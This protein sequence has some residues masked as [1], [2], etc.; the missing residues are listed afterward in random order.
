[1]NVER[2]RLIYLYDLAEADTHTETE[3]LVWNWLESGS[4]QQP[5]RSIPT[6][7]V[8]LIGQN[9]IL[10]VN[11]IYF[12]VYFCTMF[13]LCKS[14]FSICVYSTVSTFIRSLHHFYWFDCVV[15][16]VLCRFSCCYYWCCHCCCC[17]VLVASLMAIDVW[18][19]YS[20][21]VLEIRYYIACF[22]FDIVC[23]IQ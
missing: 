4:A 11:V 19:L 15:W 22:L 20:F 16:L 3:K 13:E 8:I 5:M 17:C 10:P 14:G 23:A 18:L 9:H 12:Y 21:V 7:I 6:T 2:L 1:M